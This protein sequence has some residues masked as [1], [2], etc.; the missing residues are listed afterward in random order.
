M[1]SYIACIYVTGLIRNFCIANN[2]LCLH[3]ALFFVTIF[4]QFLPGVAVVA[5]KLKSKLM[6][7]LGCIMCI[8]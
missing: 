5:H 6:Q 2:T 1:S 4:S 8:F 3:F 7:N